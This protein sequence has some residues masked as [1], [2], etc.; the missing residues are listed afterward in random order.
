MWRKESNQE[1]WEGMGG[2]KAIHKEREGKGGR[3]GA[4]CQEVDV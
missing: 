1:L 3:E 2:C 4:R